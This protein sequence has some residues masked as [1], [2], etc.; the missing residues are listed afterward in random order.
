MQLLPMCAVLDGKL[1]SASGE[2]L[3]ATKLKGGDASLELLGVSIDTRKPIDNG[4]F[5]ALKGP[6]FDAHD[7]L[8]QALEQGAL[9]V[10]TERYV[11]V[12][13][14]QIVVANTYKA[15]TDLAAWWRA[16][17][18]PVVVA[19]TGS[20]GKTSVKEMLASILQQQAPTLSTEG[21]LN[22]EI[23]VPLTLMRLRKEHRFAVLEM[24]MNQ[25][26]EISRL[27]RLGK[28]AIALVNNAGEAHLEG[29]GSIEAIAAAKGEIFEGLDADGVAII[30]ADDKYADY[31]RGVVAG[32][33]VITFGLDKPADISAAYIQ[34]GNFQQVTLSAL[35]TTIEFSL[36]GRG[37]H[38][39]MN[40]LAAVAAAVA[41]GATPEN[42][43]AGLEAYQAVGG[44]L[45]AH[46]TPFTTIFDDTY[47][48]NP[49]STK[50]ALNVVAD[51]NSAIAILGDMGELGATSSDLHQ[52]VGKFAAEQ[53]IS[54]LWCC[55]QFAQDYV[56]GYQSGNGQD[57]RAFASQEGLLDFVE[58]QN[59]RLQLAKAI[60]VKGS[61]SA[62]MENI[63]A[64]LIKRFELIASQP[65]QLSGDAA[66]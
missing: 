46:V 43:S 22:N 49:V 7:Y 12:A 8:S 5:V 52:E 2:L 47:N 66:C 36:S 23:G 28:P 56:R 35:S 53:N 33:R 13:C 45:K 3:D 26:G 10:I 62:K 15:L 63:S 39:V 32:K 17:Y 4:V 21:N 14:P 31:W 65:N 58:A 60:L 24:G 29:L 6:T 64:A 51:F 11:P 16:Q 41:A 37:R 30:N 48:A 42:I 19:I 38:N 50:A 9:A 59:E 20:V 25:T 44:R 54:S 27:T 18:E 1:Y 55:G 40:A 34:K 61:R 57:G